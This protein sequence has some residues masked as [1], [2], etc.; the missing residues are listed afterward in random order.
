MNDDVTISSF[1]INKSDLIYVNNIMT[2]IIRNQCTKCTAKFIY[3][4]ILY[5]S[6]FMLLYKKTE[7]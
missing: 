1:G 6:Q 2:A 3:D 7:I 4:E 5:F